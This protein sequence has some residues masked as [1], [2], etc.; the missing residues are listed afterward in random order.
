[1][2]RGRKGKRWV[3]ALQRDLLQ[4]SERLF[5]LGVKFNRTT[6]KHLVLDIL[7]ACE[8]PDYSANMNDPRTDDLLHTKIALAWIQSSKDRYRILSSAHTGKPRM[9][10]AKEVE[11]EVEVAGYSINISGLI[12]ANHRDESDVQNADEPHFVINV[13]NWKTLGFCG[14]YEA[15][16]ANVMSAGRLHNDA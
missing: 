12:S 5:S 15:K 6:L 10:S 1:M 3:D 11:V 4:E 7:Q 8:S 16:Y 2:G 9:S 13:E 14:S